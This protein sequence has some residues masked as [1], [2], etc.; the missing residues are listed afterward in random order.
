MRHNQPE[1]QKA[2]EEIGTNA[3]P[4][5]IEW[6]DRKPN[7]LDG[8]L[9][10]AY[11]QLPASLQPSRWPYGSWRDV[12]AQ[13]LGFLG[14]NAIPAI[15][16]LS[17]ALDQDWK[18]GAPPQTFFALSKIGPAAIPEVIRALEANESRAPY[19]VFALHFISENTQS[20]AELLEIVAAMDRIASHPSESVRWNVVAF[21]QLDRAEIRVEV[22]R[23]W[24]KLLRDE[25]P[26]VRAAAVEYGDR[27]PRGSPERD[28]I[29]QLSDDP[30]ANVRAEVERALQKA[31]RLPPLS[32]SVTTTEKP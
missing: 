8:L 16:A 7:K 32:E 25:S 11:K 21:L 3:L 28:L 1:G 17:R 4:W 12:S 24:A 30:D 18:I 31:G 14:T 27:F 13:S 19:V 15:P 9:N 5:L 22:N 10:S 20:Q 26:L 23:L 2:L 6:L 29:A